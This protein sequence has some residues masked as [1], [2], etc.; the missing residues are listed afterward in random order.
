MGFEYNFAVQ[1]QTFNSQYDNQLRQ[2]PSRFYVRA[3]ICFLKKVLTN[4]DIYLIIILYKIMIAKGIFM[5]I[6][7]KAYITETRLNMRGGDGE[8][9]LEHFTKESLPQNV[10]LMA[11]ITLNKGCSIGYHIHEN[12]TEAFFFVS[13]KGIVNDNGTEKEV[14]AGDTLITASGCGHSVK[15]TGDEP[16]V[17]VA[18][19]I[20]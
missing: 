16:L 18:T 12:E 11:K 14:I 3:G 10:R 9:I 6:S 1:K 19:I 5:F 8:V 13:G 15:N 4:I 17:I 7:S 2:M 20:L